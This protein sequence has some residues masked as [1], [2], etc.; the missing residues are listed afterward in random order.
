MTFNFNESCG[1]GTDAAG[2]VTKEAI[3][4]VNRQVVRRGNVPR[5]IQRLARFHC[6][7]AHWIRSIA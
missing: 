2:E 1:A 5:T 4:A 3:G 7:I 6:V